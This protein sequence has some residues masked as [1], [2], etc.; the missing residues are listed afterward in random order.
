MCSTD[1]ASLRARTR[2]PGS[3]RRQGDSGRPTTA[4]QTIADSSFAPTTTTSALLA[5]EIVGFS[6]LE[7]LS[8]ARALRCVSN[9]MRWR[10]MT[11]WRRAAIS[12]A[13]RFAVRALGKRYSHRTKTEAGWLLFARV[14]DDVVPAMRVSW[15][16][17]RRFEEMRPPIEVVLFRPDLVDSAALHQRLT[18]KP[19]RRG[20]TS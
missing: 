8:L 11:A 5:Y 14:G 12:R 10:V 15:I 16:P 2:D 13:V 9:R 17:L 4:T 18:A 19:L 20:R 3:G 7:M 1:D 6:S